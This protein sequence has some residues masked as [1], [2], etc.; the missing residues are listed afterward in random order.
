MENYLTSEIVN[1]LEDYSDFLNAYI[2]I[3]Q[4][5]NNVSWLKA[6]ILAAMDSKLGDASLRELSKELGENYSTL[7]SYVRVSRAFPQ[8]KRSEKASFS[9]H[10]QCSFSDRFNT[11][12]KEFSGEERFAWLNQAVDENM[13]TR[14]L[15]RAIQGEKEESRPQQ[16]ESQANI[17]GSEIRRRLATVVRMADGG[18]NHSMSLLLKIREILESY[19]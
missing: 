4:S 3:D 13:S 16:E 11:E 10:F 8:D 17:I 9:A 2:Q 15:A 12:T 1:N 18:N 7:V 6:D 19:A 14:S 5:A